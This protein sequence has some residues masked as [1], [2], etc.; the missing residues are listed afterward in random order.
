VG[1]DDGVALEGDP[2]EVRDRIACAVGGQYELVCAA[3]RD[4]DGG[5]GG[6]TDDPAP[7]RYARKRECRRTD[8]RVDGSKLY[9]D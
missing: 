2:C 1:C 3:L 8:C 6:A 5:G 9:C 4:D 7:L